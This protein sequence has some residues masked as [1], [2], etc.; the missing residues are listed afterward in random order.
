LEVQ[1]NDIIFDDASRIRED[2][3][4]SSLQ[5]L[6]ESFKNVGKSHRSLLQGISSWSLV[7][8]ALKRHDALLGRISGLSSLRNSL[9]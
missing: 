6:V 3:D 1:V 4:E 9:R 5:E 7:V 8:V 2:L